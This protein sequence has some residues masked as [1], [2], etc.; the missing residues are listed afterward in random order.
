VPTGRHRAAVSSRRWSARFW[1]GVAVACATVAIG[2]LLPLVLPAAATTSSLALAPSVRL[3]E[4]VATPMPASPPVTV[5]IPAL[6]VTADV[7]RLGLEEDGSME[8]PSGAELV[9]WYEQGPTPGEIGPAVLAAHVDW[10]DEP[11]VFQQ[12]T[13]LEP[14]DEVRVTRA[15]GTTAVFRVQRV[16]S[17][18]K[19]RFPTDAV[20]GDLDHAG[21][22][23]ITCGGEFDE[24]SGDY[25]DNVVV[26]ADLTG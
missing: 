23:L 24:S 16:V 20:Y 21:L 9:G 22:R 10:A 15:D 3:A 5:A 17:Y 18:P 14:G 8:V 13:A 25:A 12:V 1:T 26:F 4:P 7:V 11:G 19:A 6:D 2:A